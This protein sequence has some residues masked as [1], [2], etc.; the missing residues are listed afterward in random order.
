[1]ANSL[2]VGC[3]TAGMKVALACPEKYHPDAYV[4]N[5]AKKYSGCFEISD[6]I[7]EMAKDADVLVTDVWA[8]MGMEKDSKQR[9]IDFAKYKIDENVMK[10]AKPDVIV[11]HCLPAH[12]GEEITGEIFE[13]HAEEIFDE[14]ENRLHVQKAVMAKLM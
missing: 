4:M 10:A 11:Q 9:Q 1:M 5:F 14:A 3:L 13:A 6:N 12:K 2:T 8:S 7:L